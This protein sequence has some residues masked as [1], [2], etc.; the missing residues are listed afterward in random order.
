M[1]ATVLN[2][3][4]DCLFIGIS[5]PVIIPFSHVHATEIIDSQDDTS[6]VPYFL[7]NMKARLITLPGLLKMIPTSMT[8]P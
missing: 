4:L 8:N 3:P 6:L 1:I 2:S 5:G 7:G